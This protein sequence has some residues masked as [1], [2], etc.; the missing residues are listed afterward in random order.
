MDNKSDFMNDS[1]FQDK[2]K[3]N[4]IESAKRKFTAAQIEL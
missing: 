3:I 1:L 4:R 2:P